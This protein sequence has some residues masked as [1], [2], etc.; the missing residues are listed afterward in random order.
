MATFMAAPHKGHMVAILRVFAYLRKHISCKLV[1][2]PQECDW[3]NKIWISADWKESYPDI[4]DNL[5]SNAP[6][7]RG[8]SIQLNMFCDASHATS[9]VTRQSTTGIIIFLEWYS[10][11]MVFS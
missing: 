8:K 6:K 5:P 1:V 7:P 2:D 10:S 3:S 4:K 9:L 11:E